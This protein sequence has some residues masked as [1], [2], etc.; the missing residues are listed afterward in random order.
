MAFRAIMTGLLA[1]AQDLAAKWAPTAL[2]PEKKFGKGIVTACTLITMADGEAEE[3]E[4]DAAVDF[5]VNIPEIGEYLGV[6]A[7]NEVLAMQIEEL[8]AAHNKGTAMFTMTI[9]KMAAEIRNNVENPEWRSTVLAVAEAM[10]SS[11][12][13]GV[14]GADEQKILDR[15]N[16]LLG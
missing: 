1:Q 10:A 9:N 16:A 8:Q 11:N 3:S 15:L 14:A 6:E 5:I 4:L 12:S 13:N 2:S 7:A